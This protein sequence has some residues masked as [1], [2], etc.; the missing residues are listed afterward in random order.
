MSNSRT[1]SQ[2]PFSALAA[3][4]PNGKLPFVAPSVQKLGDLAELTQVGGSL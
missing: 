3:D 4:T 1:D 2:S